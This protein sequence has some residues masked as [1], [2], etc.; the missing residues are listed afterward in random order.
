MK[1]SLAILLLALPAYAY[2][3][4]PD[5]VANKYADAIYRVE[6]GEKAT[7]A[8]GIRS[9]HYA[10]TNEARAICI[11]TVKNNYIRWQKA[12]CTNNYEE[13]LAARYCPIGADND[14]KGLNRNWL[15]NFQIGR[16]H[17]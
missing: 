11:R 10:T 7:Y 3:P 1:L 13:F 5:G 6:G 8:Y 15:N 9:V 4:L 12:G 16:A 17:V 2:T 14:P